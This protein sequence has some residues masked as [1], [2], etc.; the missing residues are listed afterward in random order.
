MSGP[1]SL[2][3]WEKKVAQRPFLV[4]VDAKS[5]FDHLAKPTAGAGK[6]KRAAID[7]QFVRETLERDGS[8]VRWTDARY[9]LAD[10]LTKFQDGDLIRAAMREGTATLVAEVAALR[11]R[12][13][14]KE[15][16]RAA[17]VARRAE[18]VNA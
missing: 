6:D 7:L 8:V 2:G 13:T 16:R 3:S 12:Q 14:E 4:A 9:Q 18:P 17:R 15:N 5:V 11:M 10:D 1:F